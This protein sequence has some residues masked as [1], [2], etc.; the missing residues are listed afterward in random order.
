MGI[1]V[2]VTVPAL[3]A[4][5]VLAACGGEDRTADRFSTDDPNA[6]ETTFAVEVDETTAAWE[7]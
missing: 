5:V 1:R 3:A 2:T 4:L 6:E 7:P